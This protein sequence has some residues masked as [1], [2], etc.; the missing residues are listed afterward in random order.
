MNVRKKPLVRLGALT[1]VALLLS[2]VPTAAQFAVIDAANLNQNILQALRALQQIQNQIEQLDTMYRNLQRIAD[3]SWRDLQ[4][5]LAHLNEL[6][7]QGQAL[8]YSIDNLF[9]TYR[10]LFA[11]AVAMEE[12][13]YE[14]VFLDWT[15][16]ALDTL[17]AT[18]DSVSA[19]SRDY[20]GTQ[21]QIAELQALANGAEGNLEALNV[22]NMLQGHVA[23]EVAK[24]NQMLAASVNAQ[25]VY[26]GYLVNLDAN[27]EATERWV[28]DNGEQPFPHYTGEGGSNGVPGGWPY[29]CFG[30]AR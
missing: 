21:A 9:E 13:L 1:L 5:W 26:W 16:T 25:N 4:V 29:P 28:L 24:L 10:E 19:Q 23:Q 27:R 30:C 22:S 14:E 11:G 20:G 15:V 7:R 18:L 12:P 2:P 8:A 3:P 17:A 6:A